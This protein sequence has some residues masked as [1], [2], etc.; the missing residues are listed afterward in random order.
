MPR[1]HVSIEHTFS[2]ICILCHLNKKSVFRLET[3]KSLFLTA[4]VM[5]KSVSYLE[6]ICKISWSGFFCHMC[7]RSCS[8]SSQL[9]PAHVCFWRRGCYCYVGSFWRT[10][11]EDFGTTYAGGF[12]GLR[13]CRWRAGIII[14][15]SNVYN[16]LYKYIYI[17]IYH[18][19]VHIHISYV[20]RLLSCFYHA[21]ATYW[22]LLLVVAVFVDFYYWMRWRMFRW[23]MVAITCCTCGFI[24]PLL[25]VL[26]SVASQAIQFQYY[27]Q[28]SASCGW[29]MNVVL[30]MPI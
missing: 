6:Y 8:S 17:Y 14:H 26:V 2:S 29:C 27:D 21:C 24:W 30:I 23:F 19:Y 28:P 4:A 13:Y 7:C 11:T 1:C 16:W 9:W 25:N 5:W 3:K 18:M 15:Q 12:Y 22:C 10:V 20:Y